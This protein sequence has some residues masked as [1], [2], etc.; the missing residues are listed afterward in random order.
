M[1]LLDTP[2]R[3]FITT[4]LQ[5]HFCPALPLH[6]ICYFLPWVS[7]VTVPIYGATTASSSPFVY[8]YTALVRHLLRSSLHAFY[9]D[10]TTLASP[11]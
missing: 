7:D 3:L 10:A 8:P 2:H 4:Q 9:I 5:Q 6:M 1:S 11:P